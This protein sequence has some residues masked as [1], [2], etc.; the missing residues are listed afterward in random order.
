[1][2]MGNWWIVVLMLGYMAFAALILWLVFQYKLRRRASE[3]EE[4]ERLLA[5]FTT[6]QELSDFLSSPGGE[7]FFNT[8][9]RLSPNAVRKLAGAITTGVILLCVGVGFFIM[10]WV[11]NPAGDRIFVPATLFTLIGIGVLISAAISAF[12]LRRSG[13]LP[14]NGEGRG[15]DLP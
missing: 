4:R 14:R 2:E 12:L 6:S 11:G 3:A 13:L 15:T 9:A 7:R 5:R 1:M 10:G 8:Q